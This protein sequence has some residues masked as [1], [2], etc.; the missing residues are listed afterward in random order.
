MHSSNHACAK[1]CS[2]SFAHPFIYVCPALAG[3][4]VVLFQSKPFHQ[5]WDMLIHSF[6][7]P[8]KGTT[9]NQPFSQQFC[10]VSIDAR[11]KQHCIQTLLHSQMLPITH[12][13]HACFHLSSRWPGSAYADCKCICHSIV[14]SFVC[15][16]V[17]VESQ[18]LLWDLC[19]VAWRGV[20]KQALSCLVAVCKGLHGWPHQRPHVIT[21]SCLQTACIAEFICWIIIVVGNAFHAC[22]HGGTFCLCPSLILPIVS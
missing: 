9:N 5:H 12:S 7:E 3:H 13:I 8:A 6:W 19:C 17:F 18:W 10:C 21:R 15:D 14:V 20:S 2:H 11:I 16:H 1:S 4:H 22:M